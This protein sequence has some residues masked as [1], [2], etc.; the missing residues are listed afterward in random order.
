MLC[1]KNISSAGYTTIWS[2]FKNPQQKIFV[3]YNLD[4]DQRGLFNLNTDVD[5]E[6]KLMPIRCLA[7]VLL[8]KIDSYF[9]TN[10]H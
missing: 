1:Y 4:R 10:V 3:E 5:L 2:D 6:S 9:Y 8:H 7:N